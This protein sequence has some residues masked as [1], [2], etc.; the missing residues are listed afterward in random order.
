VLVT[1]SNLTISQMAKASGVRVDEI[2]SIMLKER[3]KPLQ[4]RPQT[5]DNVQQSIIARI[6]FFEGKTEWLIFESE[7][8]KN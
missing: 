8:N 3:I 5:L 7:L 4:S 6:L 2:R 1:M